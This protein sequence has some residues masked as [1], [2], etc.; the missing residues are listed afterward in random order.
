[1]RDE[2]ALE[3]KFIFKPIY[4][5]FTYN[6]ILQKYLICETI[7]LRTAILLGKT[8]NIACLAVILLYI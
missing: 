7:L 1:M 4:I 2:D 8:E 3:G 5:N 6:I